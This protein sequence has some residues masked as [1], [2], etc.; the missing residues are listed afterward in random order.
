MQGCFPQRLTAAFLEQGGE[1]AVGNIRIWDKGSK[2][3]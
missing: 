1:M 2:K 3:K